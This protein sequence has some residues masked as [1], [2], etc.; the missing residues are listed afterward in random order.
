[1]DVRQGWDDEA[2]GLGGL[3]VG[4]AEDREAEGAVGGGLLA[5]LGA[6][7]G[8]GE[9]LGSCCLKGGQ[10][11][12]QSFQ[13]RDAVRSPVASEPGEDDGA[14]LEELGELDRFG[15]AVWV[16]ELDL[17]RLGPCGQGAFGYTSRDQAFDVFVERGAHARWNLD[18]KE[19][20]ADA[21]E[22][23]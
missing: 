21:V 13:L 10:V 14:A 1:M 2:E 20:V 18:G 7:G 12:L 3:V 19:V 11:G 15:G 6:L 5:V 9:E 23:T 17:G 4:V 16:V 22:A 8:R